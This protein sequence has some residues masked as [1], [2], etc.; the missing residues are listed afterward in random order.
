MRCYG[1]FAFVGLLAMLA[2]RAGPGAEAADQPPTPPEK[3]QAVEARLLARAAA[4]AEKHRQAAATVRVL[5]ADG[6]PVSGARVEVVQTGHQFLFGCIIFD[7]IRGDEPYKGELFTQR[8]GELFNFA[9]FPFYW[10][11]YE[12][13]PG[14]PRREEAA[15]VARWCAEQGIATKGHP[16]VWTHPAGVPDWLKGR[17]PEERERLVLGRV[18]REVEG[19]RGLIDI[20][21]VVNEPVHTRAWDH[22]E[23]RDYVSEPIERIADYVEKAFRAAHGANP[24][25]ELILNEYYT[26][27]RPEDRERFYQLVEELKRRGTPISGLGIQAH[28]PRQHWFPPE[29][30][31]VTFE[32]LAELGYPLH[33]TE[34]IPQSGGK[35]IT[36]GWRR[37]TWTEAA[38]ADCAEQLYRLAFGH[39]AVRSVNWWG[40][41]DRRIW[42]PGG[43]LIDREYEPKPVYDRLKRL[44]H[45]EWKTRLDAVTDEAGTVS[46]R[47]FL[48]RYTV[49]VTRPGEQAQEFQAA[50][51]GDEENTWEVKPADAGW[52][53]LFDGK[54]LSAWQ[55]SSTAKWVVEDGV[56]ALAERDDGT[57]NNADYLWTKQQYGDFVL[58]LEFKVCPGYANSGVF[59]RTAD[60]DDPVYTGIEVQVSNSHGR[61]EI[62]RGGTAGAIYDCLAPTKNLARPAGEWNQYRITCRESLITVELNGEQVLKMDLDRWTE[63]GKNPDGTTNKFTKPLRDFARQGYIGLQ[64][65]GRPVW[66]RNIRIKQLD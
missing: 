2:A 18:R 7:L 49:R 61:E 46:F 62:S 29:Q 43:G 55:K 42:L 48:G 23:S 64:D 32:R 9:V 26:I 41:S 20:W 37:G 40:F 34:F 10:K 1:V 3:V 47:G 52:T 21:D 38:Q 66:Y 50:L 11:S 17:S 59:L 39:P 4:N 57:L 12:P 45:D 58:E 14:E 6:R 54:D 24:D 13:K 28:E 33:I 16:L 30:V 36:G 5:S 8:F 25:A 53:T 27:A 35:E 15:R 19:F 56:I 60:L 65:H 44:I 22:V 63:T 51:R 31:W